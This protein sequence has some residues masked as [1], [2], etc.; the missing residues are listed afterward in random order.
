[1][2]NKVYAQGANLGTCELWKK[3]VAQFRKRVHRQRLAKLK[4]LY[5]PNLYIYVHE[6]PDIVEKIDH[7]ERIIKF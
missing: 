6:I 7:E 4:C 5:A 1:M 2:I 3:F